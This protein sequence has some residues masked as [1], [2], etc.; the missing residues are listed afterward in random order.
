MKKII[1]LKRAFNVRLCEQSLHSNTT[2][3]E[4]AAKMPA[5][6]ARIASV[7]LHLSEDAISADYRRMTKARL[8]ALQLDSL[9]RKLFEL[10]LELTH[11]EAKM[12]RGAGDSLVL[13]RMSDLYEDINLSLNFLEDIQRYKEVRHRLAPSKQGGD[14]GSPRPIRGLPGLSKRDVIAPERVSQ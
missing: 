10:S 4:P 11:V 1:S 3:P 8:F 14:R 13:Q 9:F 7:I 5:A 6:M 2:G 12:G